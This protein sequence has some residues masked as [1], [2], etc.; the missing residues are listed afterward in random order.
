MNTNQPQDH[1]KPRSQ[2]QNLACNSF[3]VFILRTIYRLDLNPYICSP[4][5]PRP[6]NNTLLTFIVPLHA[7]NRSRLYVRLCTGAW[8]WVI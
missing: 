2:S 3:P 5:N 6:M 4:N 7:L 8:E 1:T